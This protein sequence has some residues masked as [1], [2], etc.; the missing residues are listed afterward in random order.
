MRVG[1]DEAGRGPVLGSMF[2]AA[3]SIRD[4]DGLPDGIRDSKELSPSVRDELAE[5]IAASAD[6]TSLVEVTPPEIDATDRNLNQLTLDASATAVNGILGTNTEQARVVADACDVSEIRY[7][8][9]LLAQLP[10]GPAVAA[11]HDADRDYPIVGAASIIAKTAREQHVAELRSEYGEVGSGYPSDPTT[12]AF[13]RAYFDATG[14]LPECARESWGTC[15]DLK[16][17]AAQESIAKFTE[18]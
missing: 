12:R 16:E 4:V 17:A 11:Y 14:E 2:V 8:D 1:V 7:Q 13:L 18:L 15:R 3:V 10:D 5:R 9:K 6:A